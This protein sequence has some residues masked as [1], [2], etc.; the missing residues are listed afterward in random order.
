[1]H[2]FTS[3]TRLYNHMRQLPKSH[4]N[5]N[6]KHGINIDTAKIEWDAEYPIISGICS[7]CE[8][9]ISGTVV[10]DGTCKHCHSKINV[11]SLIQKWIWAK[12]KV[13]DVNG[14]VFEGM[15]THE[16]GEYALAKVSSNNIVN[17]KRYIQL[18]KQPMVMNQ[19]IQN[20]KSINVPVKILMSKH[21]NKIK[22]SFNINIQLDV[23]DTSK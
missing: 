5:V 7:T 18:Q 4:E 19:I 17:M 14:R 15:S 1:M 23:N 3:I 16:F 21:E 8:K 12:F 13:T 6:D 10:Q 20:L 22:K 9:V 11:N 2:P